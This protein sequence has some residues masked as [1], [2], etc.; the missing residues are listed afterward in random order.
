MFDR[1]T[2]GPRRT[3]FL[4]RHEALRLGSPPTEPKH[5]LVGLT[6]SS[7]Q[8]RGELLATRHARGFAAGNRDPKRQIAFQAAPLAASLGP[9]SP[10]PTRRPVQPADQGRV[11]AWAAQADRLRQSTSDRDTLLGILQKR[12]SVASTMLVRRVCASRP[13]VTVSWV[14]GYTLVY[15][16]HRGSG[17]GG[18]LTDRNRHRTGRAPGASRSGRSPAPCSRGFSSRPG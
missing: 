4:A 13:C 14:G 6:R 7:N 10:S 2:A 8:H 16:R 17:P 1:Y 12:P 11:T 5:L 15:P 3:L 18:H 9:D